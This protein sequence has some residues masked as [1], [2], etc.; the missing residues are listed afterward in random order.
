[1]INRYSVLNTNTKIIY[2]KKY[3]IFEKTFKLNIPQMNKKLI[4]KQVIKMIKDYYYE[5]NNSEILVPEIISLKIK[6][7]KIIC[8]MK[9]EGK[10]FIEKK[11]KTLSEEILKDNLNN[12]FAILK[13]AKLKKIRIDPHIKNFVINSKNQIFYVDI[14]PPYTDKYE[15]LRSKYYKTH[16]EKFICN[17]NF[18]FFYPINLFYHFVADLIKFNKIYKT[19]IGFI[20]N[21]LVDMGFIKS[22]KKFFIKK[23]NKIIEIEQLRIKKNYYLI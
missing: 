20:Y 18:T 7:K 22:S 13:I 10:N 16:D 14:F 23:I 9:Y 15:N 11:S 4:Q 19:K 8:R 12:I 17:K 6:S 3:K 2:S 21:K 1:M 5:I